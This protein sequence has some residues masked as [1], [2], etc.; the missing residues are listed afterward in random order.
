MN[1]LP[2]KEVCTVLESVQGKGRY[3]VTCIARGVNNSGWRGEGEIKFYL[4][5]DKEFPTICGTG[6]EDYFCGSNN[7]KNK[8]TGQYK[9]F[10]TA[11]AGM[12][13]VLRP[14]GVYRPQTRFGLYRRRITDPVRFT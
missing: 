5:G 3:V 10:S 6:T 2:Y 4:D 14:D 1:P 12:P 13:Q 7:F 8:Q 9:K 11:Y